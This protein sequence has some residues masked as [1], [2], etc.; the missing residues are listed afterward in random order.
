MDDFSD[1]YIPCWVVLCTQRAKLEREEQGV[2]GAH[3]KVVLHL[4]DAD[5]GDMELPTAVSFWRSLL[6]SIN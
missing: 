2:T 1:E 4:S 5:A 3:V 6:G